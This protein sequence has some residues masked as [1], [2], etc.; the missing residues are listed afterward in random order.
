MTRS[1]TRLIRPGSI[2]VFGGKEARRVIEQCDKMGFKGEIWPVHPREDEIFGRRCYRSV[3]DLPS[4]P[5]AC[6]VGVNRQLTIDIV[7]DLSAKGAGGAICYASGFREAVSE[8]ADGNDLQDALV[9]AAGDMPIVGPNCYGFINALDGALLWPDQH[10]MQRVDRGVAVLTQSSNIAC[11]ISMQMRGLPLAYIMTAGN[12]AQTGL[13][14]LAIAALEDPRVTAVGLHI[15]GFDSIEALQRLAARARELKKPVVTLKVGKSEQAQLAT[16]SH[17]ASLAGNDAVSGALLKRLGIGRVDTLPELLETLKLLHLHPPLKNLDISSMSCSGGE[18][19]LMADAGVRRKTVFRALKEEQRQPL[20]ESLGDMVTIA[21][22]LDY[23][24]FVW[25][26]REKQTTAFTAMMKGDYALNLVVLDFPRQDRCDAADWNTT[27]EA[28][29]ASARATGA[30][31]GIVASLGENMPEET[32][33]SLMAA[34]V[35]AFC[36]IDEALAAAEISAGIGA[37]WARPAPMPLLPAKPLPGEIVT[38]SESE[39]KAELAKFGLAVPI[40]RVA[41]TAAEAADAAEALGFPVVLKGLGVA[42]KTEAGAVKLNLSDRQSVL[43]AADAMKNVATGYLV[44]KMI[45]R[46]VAEII[47]GALRDPVAGL[48]LT[49]G[50]GGILVELLE[51]S[52]ILTLP[53]TP[54]AIGEAICGLKI[55][56]LLDGYR[57]SPK[58]DIEALMAAVAAVASYVAANASKLEELDINP[59]MVLPQG[60]GTVAADALIRRRK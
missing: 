30:V 1:L 22:P 9:A 27:C 15:E 31:A 44:E 45:A 4:A 59:I 46:P 6:F 12:Q 36:G 13:S 42:H 58:G 21:N 38:L 25:G 54:E 17:T 2:A 52:A 20:R 7:R 37:A 40:G 41:N 60:S 48:V 32:A 49:V 16:V 34:G 56:K 3:A 18:A 19:S 55:R 28:V 29:V 51:D 10:G 8:L 24:T 43:D 39:A 57:G 11:N 50:A 35:V 53:T 23:H 47:V 5:D 26:N 14:E 33:L